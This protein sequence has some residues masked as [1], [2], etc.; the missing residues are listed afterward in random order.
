M[1]DISRD[2][3]LAH[4]GVKG[5]KWGV[6][7]AR[8]A[9]AN[10]SNPGSVPLNKLGRKERQAEVGRRL[11]V[12]TEMAVKDPKQLFLLQQG[13]YRTMLSG[14]EF[15]DALIQSNGR[16]YVTDIS[17]VDLEKG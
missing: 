13:A 16:L 11:N 9:E 12:A 10:R 6:K 14:K 8:A 4:F 1:T 2:E 3:A 7:K 5:Q 15:T 17:P